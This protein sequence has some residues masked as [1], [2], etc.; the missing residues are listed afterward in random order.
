MFH[1]PIRISEAFEAGIGA[2]GLDPRDAGGEGEFG[3][4]VPFVPME[5]RVATSREASDPRRSAAGVDADGEGAGTGDGCRLARTVYAR[6]AMT[7][8]T[9]MAE[10]GLEADRLV[11]IVRTSQFGVHANSV[12]I[13]AGMDA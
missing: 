8:N 11:C 5:L 12:V 7:I 13:S 2:G 10:T 3:A 4:V 9:P 1:A 6:T